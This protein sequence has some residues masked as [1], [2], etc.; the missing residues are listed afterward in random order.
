MYTPPTFRVDERSTI[1]ELIQATRLSTLVTTTADGLMATPLPL[2]LSAQEGENGVLYGHVARA[3][4]QWSTPPV[5]DAMVIF[6]GPD[7]YITPSWYAT[8]RDTGKVVP[9]WNYAAVHAY[10]L[11]EFFDDPDRLLD[12]VTRL[13][14]HYEQQRAAPWAVGDAP[15]AFTT[16]QLRGIVG[17]RLPVARFEAKRKM[18]Q[19][20]NEADRE[21][22]ING[23]AASENAVDRLVATMVPG[24]AGPTRA[25]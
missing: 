5:G 18:S 13:T 24:A 6:T 4:G 8:K 14:D 20:R 16:A 23:L 25:T 9:T 3:N 15:P 7:A 19:N 12:V 21:G 1:L 17:L 22:V 11:V 10:G 2:L